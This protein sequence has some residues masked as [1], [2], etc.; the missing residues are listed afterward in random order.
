MIQS[1][2][3]RITRGHSCLF[4]RQKKV[5]CD[6]QRPCSTCVR[7]GEQCR[8]G[9]RAEPPNRRRINPPAASDR[10]LQRLRLYEEALQANGIEV[11]EGHP[12]SPCPVL[13][14]PPMSPPKGQMIIKSGSSQYVEKYAPWLL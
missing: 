1:A 13:R 9:Q 6:G 8:A 14:D 5:R 10:L 2:Q 11:D 3:F 7:N 4:C 12:P